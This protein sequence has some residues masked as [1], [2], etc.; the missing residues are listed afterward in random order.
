MFLKLD[1]ECRSGELV[2]VRNL[3]DKERNAK[4]IKEDDLGLQERNDGR[5]EEGNSKVESDCSNGELGD[6]GPLQLSWPFGEVRVCWTWQ[7]PPIAM[8]KAPR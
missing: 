8:S 7:S 1:L 4:T 6:S 5:N 3:R 2:G